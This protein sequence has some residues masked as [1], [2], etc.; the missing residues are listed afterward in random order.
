MQK[1]PPRVLHIVESLNRGATENWLV[2]MLRHARRRRENV[3][4]TFYCE[5]GQTGAMDEEARALGANVIHSPVPIGRKGAFIRALREE[6]RRGQYDVLHCHHDLVSAV[7]LLAAVGMPIRRRIV[8]VHNAGESV[9]TPNRV[10][11]LVLRPLLRRICLITADRI[12]GNS[13]HSLDTFLAGRTRRE[14]R[15]VVHYLGIDPTPFLR[16]HA[17]RSAFRRELGLA[18]DSRL[19]L[20]AGRIVPEK[21]P[22][23]AVD[24]LAEMH[25]MDRSVAGVFVG[26]GSLVE[27]V[28]KHVADLGLGAVIRNLGWRDDIAEIMCCCDWFILP[29]L[30]QP[31]EGFGLVV[32][33][34]QLGGL[35]MLLSRGIPDGPLLPAAMFRRLPLA[36]GAN[37]WAK[38]AL[39]LS[40]SPAPSPTDALAALNESPMDM[41][42][43]LA[44]LLALHA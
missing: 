11:Q 12:V 20:F 42:R 3:D 26:S 5:L 1:A 41:D 29:S 14:G 38:A 21:N 19:L 15:D 23:F 10:K 35:R 40:R 44:G 34:A 4:W 25:Q 13:N 7:Y 33:E 28:C 27:P 6:L 8:H 16:A 39:E 36:A 2:R 18:E 31:M 43:A 32:I 9:R 37:E 24:V 22:L 17:D 30:E